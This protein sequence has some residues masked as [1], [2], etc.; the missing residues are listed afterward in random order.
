MISSILRFAIEKTERME[1]IPIQK[2]FN[3][4]V[5]DATRELISSPSKNVTI[6][7]PP[8]KISKNKYLDLRKM[9]K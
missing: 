7:R 4:V 6:E 2:L 8:E 5:A 3:P 1:A 9:Y